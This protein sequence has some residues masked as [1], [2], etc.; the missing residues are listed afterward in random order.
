MLKFK[1]RLFKI[2]VDYYGN[3]IML[4]FYMLLKLTV[5][6]VLAKVTIKTTNT[7]FI[8]VMTIRFKV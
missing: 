7:C 4:Y 3:I 8:C 1:Q 2:I 5:F 6:I